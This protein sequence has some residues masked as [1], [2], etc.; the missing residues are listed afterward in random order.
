MKLHGKCIC[1][2]SRQ[3]ERVAMKMKPSLEN[4]AIPVTK[5]HQLQNIKNNAYKRQ[6]L[7]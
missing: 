1:I 3:L 2:K 7:L 5:T 6:Q 4:H